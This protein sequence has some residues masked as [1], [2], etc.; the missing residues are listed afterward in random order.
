[1]FNGSCERYS[2]SPIAVFT[3]V[4]CYISASST[5]KPTACLN[6]DRNAGCCPRSRGSGGN[7]QPTI[8]HRLEAGVA[9]CAP[10]YGCIRQAAARSLPVASC[11]NNSSDR[12]R[13]QR[14]SQQQLLDLWVHSTVPSGNLLVPQ[15]TRVARS[16]Q[17]RCDW[18]HGGLAQD[19]ALQRLL[20]SSALRPVS[21]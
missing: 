11:D 17:C 6:N 18:A 7:S 5:E 19:I 12:C 15:W 4:C 8:P 2:C 13:K 21:C 3:L 14:R 10:Q 16:V 9:S 1:M 20:G